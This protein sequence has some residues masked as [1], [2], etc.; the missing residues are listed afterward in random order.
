MSDILSR[1]QILLDANTAKF[2]QNIKTADKTATSTFSNISSKAKVMG[3]A[4][5]IASVAAVNGLVN[6]TNQ[7]VQ[8]I[9]ELERFAKLAETTPEKF[10]EMS[11]GAESVGINQEKLSDQMKDF[12]EKI[13]EFISLGSG[14]AADFFEQI[15]TKT[16]G[17]AAGARKLALEIQ[18]LS[19]PEGLQL[20][21]DKMEQFGATDKQISFFLESMAS[22]TTA[23][24]PLLR[25]GGKG[26]D[27]WAIAAQNAGAIM[28]K[29]ARA[30]AV[31]LRSQT[32]LLELQYQGLK[33]Q[34]A[35]AVIPAVLDLSIA[36]NQN[37]KDG[38]DVVSMA[39]VLGNVLRGL[40][41]I[42]N[43]VSMS[44]KL[45]GNSFG[46]L[47]AAAD[48]AQNDSNVPWYWKTTSGLLMGGWAKSKEATT[49]VSS[50]ADDNAK[51][52]EQYAKTNE[53]LLNGQTDALSKYAKQAEEAK[54]KL[55]KND[56]KGMDD[57]VAKTDKVKEA[58][59]KLNKTLKEQQQLR[60][61]INSEWSDANTQM[62]LQQNKAL[63]DLS[64]AGFDNATFNSFKKKIEDYY[65]ETAQLKQFQLEFDVNEFKL[66]EI[67]KLE[68]STKI[69]EQQIRATKNF[70]DYEKE[71]RINAA[72]ELYQ[73]QLRDIQI[74]N[75]EKLLNARQ[76]IDTEVNLLN[77]RYD[78]ERV[79]IEQ[80]KDLKLRNDLLDASFKSQ[81]KETD[82]IR[83]GVWS[84]YQGQIGVDN[85]ANDAASQRATAIQSAY[86]WELI[87]QEEYQARML[88]SEQKYLAQRANTNLS[89]G[90]QIFGS[91]TDM[92]AA[93][94]AKQSGIYKVMFAA[95]KAFAIA[96]SL[97][98]IQQGIA[99]AAANPFPLNLAAMASVAAATAGIVSNITSVAGV[100]HGGTDYVPKEASYLLDE[101]ERVL[102][103]RQNQDLTSFLANRETPQAAGG[104]VINNNTPM[105]VRAEKREDGKTYVTIDQLDQWFESSVQNPNSKA[106]KAMQQNFNSS[107]RR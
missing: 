50:M 24:I 51:I 64:K 89:Y 57:W 41:V 35:Q 15:A 107:R 97:V 20:M 22:D 95:N 37:A 54:N 56:F 32:K 36:F 103:P 53:I 34:V 9:N 43:T 73:Y 30:A 33:T 82:Q 59:D 67:Q 79:R 5:A 8:A 52:M 3:A 44:F 86:E 87:T 45:A 77:W 85:S 55:G 2:E 61:Q 39:D 21:F 58:Q 4:V 60:D 75:E 14:G 92:L 40:G 49:I 31:E 76:S 88:E 83:V 6:F 7:Q 101:G 94:G 66:S 106:S 91:M 27:E 70:S 1:V 25:D 104:I 72:K 63:T 28:D 42:A 65:F 69:Q 84:E 11:V 71:L 93:S 38:Y 81:D 98:S 80:I 62:N 23:L 74:A 99:Q 48:A 16:E 100:F 46:G 18:R 78:L 29:E 68:W 90:E 26:F 19:G 102:S 105:Q 17:S 12:N 10:Q 13:G 96:Q 47:L